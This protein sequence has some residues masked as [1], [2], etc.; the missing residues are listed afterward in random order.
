M[1]QWNQL[2]LKA[3]LG[4]EV[5]SQLENSVIQTRTVTCFKHR[6]SE[7]EY[8]LNCIFLKRHGENQVEL[9]HLR[10][11]LGKGSV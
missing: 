11:V 2:D 6:V 3:V 4:D 9:K 1:K 5:K 7:Y 8:K 10:F